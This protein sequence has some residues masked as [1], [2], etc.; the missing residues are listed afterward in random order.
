MTFRIDYLHRSE[1][2][3]PIQNPFSP[4]AGSACPLSLLTKPLPPMALL[5]RS[6]LRPQGW[7]S[8]PSFQWN[9]LGSGRD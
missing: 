3:G 2:M 8:K 5:P 1:G 4:G 7:A 6:P 9:T